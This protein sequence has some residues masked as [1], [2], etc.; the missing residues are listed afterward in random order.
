MATRVVLLSVL[1]ALVTCAGCERNTPQEGPPATVAIAPIN[2]FEPTEVALGRLA[3][4]SQIP[5]L[6]MF[7]NRTAGPLRIELVKAACGCTLLDTARY[8]GLQ[9][10]AGERV[11]VSGT[12]NVGGGLG[13]HRRQIDVLLDNGAVHS[14]IVTYVAYATYS[15]TPAGVELGTVDL[16][17]NEDVTAQIVFESESSRIIAPPQSD[18]VWLQAALVPRTESAAEIVLRVRPG[19]LPFGDAFGQLTVATND[20][21]R[22]EFV[23][24]VRLRTQARLRAV[25]PRLV[26]ASGESGSVRVVRQDGRFGEIASWTAPPGLS[27]SRS[28]DGQSLLVSLSDATND[29]SYTLEITDAAGDRARVEVIRLASTERN[30]E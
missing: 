20:P 17:S 19:M 29:A 10:G 21:Y 30:S 23:V 1:A 6:A 27:A 7:V 15:V 3:W 5:F 9:L 2:S 4:Y 8:S 13:E 24:P 11:D 28:A 25:P 22:P 12:L 26:L 16:D 14:M 18:S